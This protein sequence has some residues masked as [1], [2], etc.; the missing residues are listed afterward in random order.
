MAEVETEEGQRTPEP[1]AVRYSMSG[2]KAIHPALED[3]DPSTSFFYTPH[4]FT[5]LVSGTCRQS[6][7]YA[8]LS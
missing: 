1:L 3:I 8:R 2:Q 7:P 5:G 4:T 6:K